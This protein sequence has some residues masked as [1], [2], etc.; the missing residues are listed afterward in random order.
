MVS[1][2]LPAEMSA[3]CSNASFLPLSPGSLE[4]VHKVLQE[5][6]RS[7]DGKFSLAA[8]TMAN[9]VVLLPLYNYTLYLGLQRWY[10]QQPATPI[11]HSDAF[12][13]HMIMIEQLSFVGSVLIWFGA[14][15]IDLK[16]MYIG[17]YFTFLNLSGENSFHLMTCVERYVAVT[18]PMVYMSLRNEK[19]IKIRNVAI[20][21]A[22]LLSL[23][24]VGVLYVET[25]YIGIIVYFSF[26]AIILGILSFCSVNVLCVLFHP[27][28]LERGGHRQYVDQSKLGA[29]YT[30][31]L[32]MMALML[33]SVGFVVVPFLFMFHH[34]GEAKSCVLLLAAFWL[35]LPSN[36]VLPLLYLHRAG[37]LGFKCKTESG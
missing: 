32:I 15:S 26:T 6:F 33:R 4:N 27:Q 34:M 12:T 16:I 23:L 30:I 25:L 14:H 35:S 21:C 5:C 10:R 36:L 7:A 9:L 19:G 31:T 37:K 18:Y 3:N 1:A 24:C 22:W 17:L 29:F 28:P 8:Y 20:I 13:Y 11:S 2:C